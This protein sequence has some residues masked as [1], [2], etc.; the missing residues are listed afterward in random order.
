MRRIF[1]HVNEVMEEQQLYLD[2]RLTLGKLTQLAGTNRTQL[3]TAI[4]QATGANF[5]L[6]LAGYRMR[7][8]FKLIEQDPDRPIEEIY[9]LCGFASRSTFYR[10]FRKITGTTPMEYFQR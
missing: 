3:S 7:H 10:Q 1:K 4:N 2:P 5:N 8:L 9:P 6:W